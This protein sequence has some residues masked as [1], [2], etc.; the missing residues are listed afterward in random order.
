VAKLRSLSRLFFT[1]SLSLLALIV[2]ALFASK[3][4]QYL[5]RRRAE[6]LL[7]QLQSFELSKTPWQSAQ[8]QLKRWGAYLEPGKPC[9]ESECSLQ[10]T[11][12]EFVAG[13]ITPRNVFVKLDDYFRWRLKLSY[14]EGPFERIEL[15]LLQAYVRLGGHPARIL[16]T[17]GM[18][19]GVVWSKR[20]DVWI[21]TYGHPVDWS[22]TFRTEYTL[23]A[24]ASSVSRL[25]SQFG[26]LVDPQLMIHPDYTIGRPG[27]CTVCVAGWTKFTPYAA[28]ADV[29][30]LMQF[31]LSCLTRWSNCVTQSDIMPIPWAQYLTE[32]SLLESQGEKLHCPQFIPEVL[33]R[34]SANIAVVK[35]LDYRAASD[36]QGY[37][38]GVV[39]ARL[40]KRLKGV[41]DWRVGEVRKQSIVGGTSREILKLPPGSD[42]VLFRG[43]GFPSDPWTVSVSTCPI[44]WANES[45]LNLI[46]QGIDEDYASSDGSQE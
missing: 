45:N 5:F 33:G 30:R 11:L 18:R 31:D 46:Q 14:N 20:F 10:I 41:A 34:D 24:S 29:H 36:S 15:Y 3:I 21:D 40:V 22:G 1:T 27:G 2:L 19:N 43:R 26:G 23:F 38:T 6:L 17:I 44:T 39:S 25:G 42:L 16:A 13:Y 12:N 35:L 32:R 9:D 37:H 7:S 8:G 4:E 28:Q